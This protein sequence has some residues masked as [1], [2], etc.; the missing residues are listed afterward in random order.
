MYYTSTTATT[1]SAVQTLLSALG[2]PTYNFSV[3]GT[4]SAFS[5]L[6]NFSH[7]PPAATA[8]R[9]TVF[10][11]PYRAVETVTNGNATGSGTATFGSVAQGIS[12]SGL[13][14]F[15]SLNTELQDGSGTQ[16]TQIDGGKIATD[17]INANR[18]VIGSSTG[19]DRILLSDDKIEIFQSGQTRIKI[20]NLS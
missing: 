1:T 13:V 16:I 15:T 19:N 12:F 8:T 18:L 4:D 9:T 10:Y 6:T 3:S 5:T 17:S 2:T 7:S 14:T 11:A 20:G